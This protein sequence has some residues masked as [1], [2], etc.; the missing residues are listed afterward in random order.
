M[1][2]VRFIVRRLL[3][4]VPTLLGICVV[5]FALI[6]LP[7]GDPLAT[8][9]DGQVTARDRQGVRRLYFLDLPLLYN[10]RPRGLEARTRRLLAELHRDGEHGVKGIR[11]CGTLCVVALG[12]ALGDSSRPLSA[13]QRERLQQ[14]VAAIRR[15]HPNLGTAAAGHRQWLQQVIPRLSP[16]QLGSVVARLGQDREATAILRDRGTAALPL[17]MEALLGSSA[18]ASRAAASEVAS[19]LT[20]VEG[21][22]ARASSAVERAQ[23]MEAWTEWWYQRRRDHVRFSSWERAAGRI[24]ETRFAKWFCR[25]LTFRFGASLHDGRPVTHKLVETLPVTLLLSLLSMSLAYLVAVPLGIHAAVRR[26]SLVER[27]TTLTL[28]VLYSLPSFW[29][30]MLLI[31]LLGGVGLADLFPIYGLRSQGMEQAGTL[32]R[33]LDLLHHLVLPVICLSYGSLALIS[34]YQ[35]NAMIEVIHQDYILA[36]RA[37]GL[38]ERTVI[39]KHALRNA[40]LPM[41]TLV[42][43]QVPFLIGGSVIIERIF[44]IPGMGL[45]TFESFLN[46]DYPVIMAVSVLTALL[47]LAGLLLSDLAYAVADPRIRLEDS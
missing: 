18:G 24:T 11:R 25:V 9:D 26:G 29:V 14:A 36:A 12:R 1:S 17:V 38:G 3:I 7:P 37:R 35:R 34:R 21:R 19:D 33:A 41:I 4:A 2:T 32:A 22:L 8:A 46:R 6:H 31:L 27:A 15:D 40:L 43:L 44:N 30:A 16:P 20:G 42:G 47:T 45:L 13:A 23:V 28:F 10:P 39:F 5:T